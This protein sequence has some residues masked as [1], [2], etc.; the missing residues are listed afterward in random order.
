M[1]EE[2]VWLQDKAK[3]EENISMSIVASS[4][5]LSILILE[6]EEGPTYQ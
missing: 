3:E 4:S 5:K 2:S 1:L 6:E